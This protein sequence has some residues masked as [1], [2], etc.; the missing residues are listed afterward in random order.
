MQRVRQILLLLVACGLLV[1]LGW[2]V[3]PQELIGRMREIPLRTIPILLALF[4]ANLFVVA[5]RLWRVLSHF[6]INIRWP[7]ALRASMAGN[8]ASLFFVPLLGQV[9]GR[10]GVLQQFGVSA[11]VN[12]SIA[13]YER[14]AL[15]VTSG[16]LAFG[17]GF[18]I[19][20]RD[21]VTAFIGQMNLCSVFG[22]LTL[23]IFLSSLL[24]RGRFEKFLFLSFFSKEN[25]LCGG[26]FFLIALIGQIITVFGFVISFHAILPQVDLLLIFAASFIVS[27]AA[28]FPISAGGWGVREWASV[29]LLAVLG[30]PPSA[31][32]AGSLAVGACSSLALVGAIP[33]LWGDWC[34]KC[35]SGKRLESGKIHVTV[36]K[37]VS[38]V[39]PFSAIVAVFFQIHV[40]LTGGMVNVNLA[41]PFALL[42]FTAVL[43]N[44]VQKRIF[45]HW[46]V[47]S[48]NKSLLLISCAFCF[49]FFIGW[50]SIGVTQWALSGRLMGWVVLLGYVCVGYLLISNHGTHGL[51]RAI[52]TLLS[53]ACGV[54]FVRVVFPASALNFEGFAGNRNA[55]AFQLLVVSAFVVGYA[56]LYLRNRLNS[57]LLWMLSFLQ[58]MVFF[59]IVLSGSRT[60]LVVALVVCF[61]SFFLHPENRR[62]IFYCFL[63]GICFWILALMVP[64]TGTLHLQSNFST[65]SS[66]AVRWMA[67]SIAWREWLQKPVFGMGLGVFIQRSPSIFGF[68]M[69][70]HSTPIW[71]LA[72]FG[73]MGIFLFGWGFYRLFYYAIARRYRMPRDRALFLVLIVFV[74]FGVMH[75]IFFQRIF[76]L[77][78]GLLLSLTKCTGEG[79]IS[80]RLQS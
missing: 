7:V 73:L 70:I 47:K 5:F 37:C 12:S 50:C 10:Q 11:S 1:S 66:D 33:F 56:S 62:F 26:E 67:N 16:V 19:F 14:I 55:L 51:R 8:I 46:R 39:L 63:F 80:H 79:E 24:G 72:E 4:S 48:G 34:R 42:A 43:L 31:A 30:A 18:Y 21:E 54:I 44:A 25:L 27:F 41:D 22:A 71:I 9:A 38:W 69:V 74:L 68:P 2:F 3:D 13:A 52:E 76:W 61:I 58:G 15:A 35:A 29:H 36:E 65:E 57:N 49:S 78:I 75:E 6:G 32:L 17:G 77:A 28:S 64:Y 20:G 40:P 59:A 53:V 23:G 45:P 60:G